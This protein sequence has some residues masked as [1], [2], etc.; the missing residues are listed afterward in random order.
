MKEATVVGPFMKKLREFIPRAEVIKHHDASLIGM[1]DTSITYQGR[2][3]WAECKLYNLPRS[4]DPGFGHWLAKAREESPKQAIKA[5]R[6]NV[7]ACCLYI[8]WVKKTCVYVGWPDGSHHVKL[9]GTAELVRFMAGI[10]ARWHLSPLL[11][12]PPLVPYEG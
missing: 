11:H 2:T 12:R 10:I 6:L 4:G 8:I 9:S 5:D 1:V 3:I 7:A